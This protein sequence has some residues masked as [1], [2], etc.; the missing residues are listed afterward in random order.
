[1]QR[2]EVQ[3][4][5]RRKVIWIGPKP[6]VTGARTASMES[7]AICSRVLGWPRVAAG[8]ARETQR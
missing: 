2:E 8:Q 6:L 5:D 4:H 1:M 7:A 3:K